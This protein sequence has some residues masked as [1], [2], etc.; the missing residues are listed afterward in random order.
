M[1]TLN[2]L[3]DCLAL[4]LGMHAMGVLSVCD[5]SFWVRSWVQLLAI[6]AYIAVSVLPSWRWR[7]TFRLTMLADG[8]ELLIQFL[9]TLCINIAVV[10]VSG[11]ACWRGSLSGW[12]LL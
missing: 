3:V 2:R 8:T 4:L 5:C 12:T 1:K 7:A 9:I 6:L 11:V 10:A